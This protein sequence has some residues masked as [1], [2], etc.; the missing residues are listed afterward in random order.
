MNSSFKKS[1]DFLELKEKALLNHV[2]IYG[3]FE[4]TSRCNLNCKM[5]YV[6]NSNSAEAKASELSTEQW[7][8]IF[9]EAIDAGMLFAL[10]TGGECLLR[11]DFEELYLYLY[12]KGIFMSVNSNATL[13]DDRMA[14]FFE[15]FKPDR[16]QISVYGSSDDAYENVTERRMFTKLSTALDCLDHH[17][18]VPEIGITPNSYMKD[19]ADILQFVISRKYPLKVNPALLKPRD[20]RS[21]SDCYLT[22]DEQIE[23]DKQK[24]I[25]LGK[26]L[27]VHEGPAPTPGSALTEAK[28]G[29]PCNAGTIRAV[30]THDGKMVPCMAIPEISI[31]VLENGYTKSWEYIWR[32]MEEV[33]Q[34]PMCEGCAYKKKCFFCPVM[35]YDSL[36]SGKC[37]TEV[38][39]LM[40]KKYENGII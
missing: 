18:I 12:N 23:F 27:K 31:N 14:A 24:R 29:I 35:R 39:E 6:H 32:K 25:F 37:K 2:P 11:E 1:K 10:F 28:R 8:S 36:N 33:L 20:G 16:I 30:I 15:K 9:D 13:I 34:P 21:I 7:I 4:L 19:F 5:C 22:D 38:C 3:G 26:R 40:V 17:G